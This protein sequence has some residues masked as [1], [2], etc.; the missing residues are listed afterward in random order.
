LDLPC[1]DGIFDVAAAA[2]GFVGGFHGRIISTAAVFLSWFSTGLIAWMNLFPKS[3]SSL[4]LRE[5]LSFAK[6]PVHVARHAPGKLANAGPARLAEIVLVRRVNSL[7]K[8]FASCSQCSIRLPALS[9]PA[10]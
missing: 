3:R 8:R 9:S 6:W 7:A 2:D 4:E 5:F 1:L 10:I